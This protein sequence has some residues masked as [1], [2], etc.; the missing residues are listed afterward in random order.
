[1]LAGERPSAER[2]NGS[3]KKKSVTPTRKEKGKG[4]GGEPDLS[5]RD[6]DSPPAGF[7][8]KTA[9]WRICSPKGLKKAKT[10]GAR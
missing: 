1:M 2:D 8:S 5:I 7:L 9:G 10:G 4:S 3:M 6:W